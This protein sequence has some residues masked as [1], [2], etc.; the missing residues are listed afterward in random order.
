MSEKKI[1]EDFKTLQKKVKEFK[2]IA[3]K[4]S[5]RGEELSKEIELDCKEL[6]N[7]KAIK[8]NTKL[9]NKLNMLI[10]SSKLYLQA[11]KSLHKFEKKWERNK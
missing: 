6:K 2:K 5:V 10:E 1:K 4:D 11:V 9:I 8:Q 7:N 3:K